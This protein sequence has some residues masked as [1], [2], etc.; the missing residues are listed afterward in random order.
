[1]YNFNKHIWDI[2]PRFFIIQ[3]K[4]VLAVEVLF[5]VASGLIKVSILLFFRR[6]SARSVSRTFKWVSWLCIGFIIATSIPFTLIPIFGCRPISAFW[7]QVDVLKILGGYK[8]HCFDEGVDVF[9][10]AV[11]SATQDL[12]AAMLPTFLYWNLRIPIRQKI[13]LFG[14]FAI[15]Y[16]AVAIGALRAYYS[17]RIF[18]VT[19]DVTWETWNAWKLALLELH[20]GAMCANAPALKVFCKE[21]LKLDRLAS[22]SK[23]SSKASRSQGSKASRSQGSSKGPSASSHTGTILVSL[24]GGGSSRKDGYLSEPHTDV[25]ADPLGGVQRQKDVHFSKSRFSMHDSIDIINSSYDIEMGRCM[26][27]S[28]TDSKHVIRDE[29]EDVQ[30]LPPL[31]SQAQYS[32]AP[33]RPSTS[34]TSTSRPSTPRPPPLTAK[35][36]FGS[37]SFRSKQPASSWQ[38]R[39]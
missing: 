30:A 23:S 9:I 4:Y 3:R 7:D 15:G 2:E 14:I 38:T 26:E 6:I 39:P 22:R 21:Y 35:N 25:S 28:P 8:Y 20:V 11:V 32:D 13:A 24:C 17:W 10:A 31:W 36:S 18:F 1:V 16:G 19:Y 33:S 5:C 29:T 12:L 34:R 37:F 27:P